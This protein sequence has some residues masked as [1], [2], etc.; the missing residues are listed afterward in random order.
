VHMVQQG[1]PR[2][3]KST[4]LVYGHGTSAVAPA[5]FRQIEAEETNPVATDRFQIGAPQQ[6]R[7]TPYSHR[8][9]PVPLMRGYVLADI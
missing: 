3:H 9:I 6:L 5:Q 8:S 4:W 1:G 7:E 2:P